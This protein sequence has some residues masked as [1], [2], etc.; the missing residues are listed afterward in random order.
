MAPLVIRLVNWYLTY[1]GS[2]EIATVLLF[3]IARHSFFN[4]SLLGCKSCGWLNNLIHHIDMRWWWENF[5][6]ILSRGRVST[7]KV[8]LTTLT[9]FHIHFRRFVW[10]L[11]LRILR[12]VIVGHHSI[13]LLN[14]FYCCGLSRYCLSL[15]ELL[16]F[17]IWPE[18]ITWLIW[19]TCRQFGCFWHIN[20]ISLRIIV[21]VSVVIITSKNI[22]IINYLF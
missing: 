10:V 4:S 8:I 19:E 6:S 22:I 12:L 3:S 1:V 20:K 14:S 16:D 15:L 21:F 13:W 2:L 17:T 11:V 7:N 9:C 5:L 18:T